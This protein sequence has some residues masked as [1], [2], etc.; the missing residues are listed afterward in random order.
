MIFLIAKTQYKIPAKPL[1]TL[2]KIF[3]NRKFRGVSGLLA[4]TSEP[5]KSKR[6]GRREYA[7]MNCS[8]K[9]DSGPA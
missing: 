8:S 9:G 7:K 1:K 5:R 3:S 6:L 2:A 4:F